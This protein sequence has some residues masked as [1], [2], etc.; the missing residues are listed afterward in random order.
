MRSL[1]LQRRPALVSVRLSTLGCLA[2][3]L[4]APALAQPQLDPVVVTGTREPQA[5][6]R[7]IGDLV[8]ID[9]ETIRNSTADSVEDL[10]RRESGLQLVRGG[11]PGQATGFF[12]R[13]AGT[14][15]TL[16]LV[17]GVR[18]GSAS[19]GQAEFETLS[20]GQIERIEVL[21]GPG[22]S[23]YGADGV[24]GVVQIFTRRGNG[25][26]RLTGS[27]AVGGER[28]ALGDIGLSGS[29][30]AFDYAASVGHESSRGV[31][32][33][34]PNDAFGNY[35][36]DRDGFRRN[37]ATL[38]LGYTPA[39]GHR[40]G[41]GVLESRL[42][43]RY[44]AAEFDP[45]TFAAD[46]SPDFINRTKT[47]V[48]SIDYRGQLSRLWTT[49]VQLA[50]NVDDST[51]GA[52]APTRYVTRRQQATWQNA[53]ALAPEQQVVVAYEHLRET[54]GGDVYSDEPKRH[55]NAL[56]L[57]YTGTFAAHGLQADLRRDDNSVYGD[58][59]TGRVGYA[60]ELVRGLKVRAL[61]GTTFRAPSFNDLYFPGY[62]VATVRPER[63]RSAELGVA[64]QGDGSRL[65]ATVY[66]IDVR[67]LIGYQPDRT[68]CPAD[69]AF[70]FGCAGNVARAR[71]Q[72]ATLAAGHRW[73]GFDLRLTVD[74]LDA[75]DRDTNERLPRR[76]AHQESVVLDYAAGAW[77]AGGSLLVVGAR[78]DG[79]GRLGG[80]SVLDL[81]AGWRFLPRWRL[82]ARLSNALD[83]D[84][85]PIRDYQALGR[86]A[87]LGVRFDGEGL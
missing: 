31:S 61:G 10:I 42:R 81:R 33:L 22:S 18:I 45:V 30:D 32:T 66:R 69:P 25:A 41:V 64:W 3:C 77:T 21:R 26:P 48:H 86:Q 79:G 17:D 78:P 19:L 16:V 24:G 51:S 4:G 84:I 68:F 47:Q 75:R 35:N 2:T 40:L 55:T 80:Y 72:G 39:A 62:G 15:S 76:A 56:V 65:S 67:D 20:L 58:R 50:R 59:T 46:P 70:D 36:P 53:L 71:L 14:N 83:R 28:S 82:E 1:R 63:G 37:S 6:S 13:G 12:L 87:W 23:L 73:G 11:G 54:V 44:D 85:E 7:S 57:G 34:R 43:A 38:R 5:R 8:V 74:V 52:N 60:Y 49:T 29:T 27:V 9:A